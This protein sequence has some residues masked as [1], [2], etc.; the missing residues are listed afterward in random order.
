VCK[1]TMRTLCTLPFAMKC[2]GAMNAHIFQSYT[3]L[4]CLH[5]LHPLHANSIM[6]LFFVSR[7]V[8]DESIMLCIDSNQFQE[9]WFILGSTNIMWW[10]ASAWSLWMRLEGWS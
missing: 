2:S 5:P 1:M 4:H 3:K 6:L 8:V 10:M 7:I 9:R